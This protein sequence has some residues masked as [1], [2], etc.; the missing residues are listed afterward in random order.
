MKNIDYIHVHKTQ[1]WDGT[2]TL[3]KEALWE[4]PSLERILLPSRG[5]REIAADPG[6]RIAV[7]FTI[8]LTKL[9]FQKLRF[10]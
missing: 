3:T 10:A 4:F 7:L 2:G 5:V 9:G 1:E 8:A 6:R